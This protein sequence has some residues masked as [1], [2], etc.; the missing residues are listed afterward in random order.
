MS[1]KPWVG[2]WGAEAERM[3]DATGVKGSGGAGWLCE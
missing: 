2:M 1:V 3:V